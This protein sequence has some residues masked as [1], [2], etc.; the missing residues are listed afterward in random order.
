[1]AYRRFPYEKMKA[2]SIEIFRSYGYDAKESELI[3]DV[4]TTA[5][6][7]GI[8]SHGV[9]R[10]NL[11]PH[12]IDIGRIKTGVRTEIVYKTAVS[13]VMDAHDGEGHIASREAMELAIHMAKENGIG[14]VTVRNSNHFGIAGYY[15][16]MALKEGMM[17]ICMTN[18][19]AL[20]VPT[21]GKK[22]MLG[23]NPIAVSM[24]AQP[25]PYNLDMAT[26]VVPGGKLEVYAKNQKPLPGEWLV[27][28]DG[29]ESTDPNVFLKI[30]KEKETGGILPLGGF[31][32][33]HGGHKGFG[34]G[35]LVELM[36]GSF[37]GGANSDGVRV[38]KN[39]EKCCHFFAAID[40][41]I[42]GDR[43]KIIKEFS[44]YLMR[45][46][47]SEKAQ[48]CSRIYTP[49]EKEAENEEKV[50]REGI[51]VNEPTL[52]EIVELCEKCGIDPGKYLDI[53]EGQEWIMQRNL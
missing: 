31:G 44:E 14:M 4:I 38:V 17:G 11:Y 18:T 29:V 10:L 16:R 22:P 13:A 25:I 12:G 24:P 8:E 40:L 5:D 2:L 46:R 19:E 30:R 43:E 33:I 39:R 53:Q 6:L 15:T 3:A 47:N 36:T 35:L 32:E 51:A 27:D 37:A 41:N 50:R 28:P 49:G 48:G 42:F 52:K 23:T 1:M 45:V 21:N 34:L 26:S 20:I 7:F 9:N